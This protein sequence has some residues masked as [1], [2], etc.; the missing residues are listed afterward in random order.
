MVVANVK[1]DAP[2]E[3]PPENS[4]KILL[5]IYNAPSKVSTRKNIQAIVTRRNSHKLESTEVNLFHL[6]SLF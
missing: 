1:L 6:I 4:Q 2:I 3:N 5:R